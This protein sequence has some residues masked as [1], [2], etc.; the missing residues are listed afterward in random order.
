L[1]NGKISFY[2]KKTG[3]FE[4]QTGYDTSINVGGINENA[5][6]DNKPPNV[7][8]YI[9]DET[10]VSGGTTN[11]SPF[12]LANLEDENGINTASGIGHN[13]VAI[14][15][16]KES[17]PYLLNDYYQTN[18]DDYTKGTL[19]FP[20]RNLSVG[21]HTIT[22]KAWDVY[23]NPI[24]A[25]IQFIVVGD[26]TMGLTHGIEDYAPDAQ[27]KVYP[28]PTEQLLYV[29]H[30]EQTIFSIGIADLNGRQFY[31]GTINTSTP[32][33]I[34]QYPQGIYLV[35]IASTETHK[36]NSYKVIKK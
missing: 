8:L 4:N 15:D 36:K 14:L 24:T 12:L 23:N 31:S 6:V 2:A 19:R 13:I 1:G 5:A 11:E 30:P 10:F 16:G 7:K 29:S 17:N 21:L 34:G 26:E 3:Q 20:F 9:N 35:T 18:L 28:N 33:D 32:L 25:E 22:F 27:L